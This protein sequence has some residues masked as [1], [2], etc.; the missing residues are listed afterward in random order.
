MSSWQSYRQIETGDRL[1]VST[2]RYLRYFHE[3]YCPVLLNA[4]LCRRR[5]GW[6]SS[7]TGVPIQ[8]EPIA[9]R[10]HLPLAAKRPL[11]GRG[12]SATAGVAY[13]SP[14]AHHPHRSANTRTH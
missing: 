4:P 3:L 7:H 2:R 8:F 6:Q 14:P 13:L 11:V 12:G 5:R 10:E 1:S 9:W